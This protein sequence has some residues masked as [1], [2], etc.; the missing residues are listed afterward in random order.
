MQIF[1]DTFKDITFQEIIN[2]N[3][4]KII[5]IQL[6]GLRHDDRIVPFDNLF[7]K[8]LAKAEEVTAEGI[9]SKVKI[10]ND[11]ENLL[12]ISDGE[13]IVGAKQNRIAERSVIIKDQSDAVVPVYCVERGRWGYR[14][15]ENARFAKS[16]FSLSPRTRDKKAEFLKNSHNQST[17]NMVWQDIDEFSQKV[18]YSSETSDLGDILNSRNNENLYEKVEKVNSNG[19]IVLGTGRPF[20]EVFS[21]NDICKKH[22]NKS[23]RIWAADENTVAET[24]DKPENYFE[25]FYNSE[26]DREDPIGL[27]DAFSSKGD[28][29]GRAIF[30]DEKLVHSYMYF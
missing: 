14:D 15:R 24:F 30:H 2:I 16:E 10:I 23:I 22:L 21:H 27:E 20:I 28:N 25:K 19:F 29:N 9:V 17:Q 18:N 3:N 12:F 11:S 7:D 1:K 4:L 8:G 5:P 13:A 26:W 6:E